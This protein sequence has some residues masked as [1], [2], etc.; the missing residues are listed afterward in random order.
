MLDLLHRLSTK[1]LRVGVRRKRWRVL[2]WTKRDLVLI[3]A[4]RSTFSGQQLYGKKPGVIHI[5]DEGKLE[6]IVYI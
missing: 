1:R 2:V 6:F 4:V 3:R 5:K